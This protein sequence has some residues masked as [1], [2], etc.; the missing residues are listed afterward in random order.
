MVLFYSFAEFYV[1]LLRLAR[2][3]LLVLK[4]SCL[5]GVCWRTA[6]YQVEVAYVTLKLIEKARGGGV[7]LLIKDEWCRVVKVREKLCTPDIELLCL[8]LRPYYLP[9]E[10][11]QI[12]FTLVYIHPKADFNKA[13]R[14]IFNISQKLEALSPDAPKFIL[15]DFNNCPVKRSLR[16]YYQYVDCHTRKKKTLDL[17]FGTV[18][19]AYTATPLPPLGTSDHNVVYLRPAYRRLLER[20]KP[21]VKTVKVWDNE[22]TMALQGCF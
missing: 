8:S 21:Q 19:D 7:C 12:F 15:G 10:F 20:E 13:T 17:C 4:G 22:S 2:L 1:S 9:R 14:I 6:I 5:C 11:P 18:K 16:T 3:M